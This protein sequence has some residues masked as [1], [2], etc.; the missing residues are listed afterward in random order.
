MLG[1]GFVL[2]EAAATTTSINSNGNQSS[3]FKSAKLVAMP[4]LTI[5][6][7]CNFNAI[8][9]CAMIKEHHDMMFYHIVILTVMCTV[10]T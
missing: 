4:L 8:D 1:D 5:G 10:P 2:A 7:I 3:T 6:T 9:T